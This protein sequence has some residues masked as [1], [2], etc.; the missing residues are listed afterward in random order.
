LRT[1]QRW[2]DATEAG[3][4]QHRFSVTEREWKCKTRF[5]LT[6]NGVDARWE[7]AKAEAAKCVSP[8]SEEQR[9]Q[10]ARVYYEQALKRAGIPVGIEHMT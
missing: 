3:T 4:L 10:S 6:P 8:M 2:A 7:E 5:A 1:L 9:H